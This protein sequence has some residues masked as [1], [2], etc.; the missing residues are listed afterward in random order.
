MDM[1]SQAVTRS[2]EREGLRV[3]PNAF[4]NHTAS[5]A[6]GLIHADGPHLLGFNDLGADPCGQIVGIHSVCSF[7]TEAVSAPISG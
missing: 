7:L 1:F 3:G 6:A 5:E 4:C 2:K